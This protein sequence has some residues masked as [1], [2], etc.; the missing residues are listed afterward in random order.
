MKI[1]CCFE[2]SGVL[3]YWEEKLLL[4]IIRFGHSY[5]SN[6]FYFEKSIT[7]NYWLLLLTK[8]KVSVKVTSNLK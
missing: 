4:K 2:Y 5:F 1:D 8:I 3:S 6:Y 7:L